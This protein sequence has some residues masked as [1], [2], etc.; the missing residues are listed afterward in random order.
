[1]VEE[2]L[3][4]HDAVDDTID[5]A[6]E[7][8][9]VVTDDEEINEPDYA[10]ENNSLKK[11][12]ED[13][14]R[15]ED[16]FKRQAEENARQ[17]EASDN[18]LRQ[19]QE[20]YARSQKEARDAQVDA[21]ESALAAATAEADKAEQDFVTAGEIGDHAS[22]AKAQRRIAAAVTKIERLESD[23]F[24]MEE[25]AKAE[26]Q[27]R[28]QEQPQPQ[29]DPMDRAL[30]QSGLPQSAQDWL[31]KHPEYFNDARKNAKIQNLHYEVIED[32]KAPFSQE[33]FE[34]IEEHLGMRKKA[35]DP[36][37]EIDNRP[38]PT[39][40]QATSVQAPPSREVPNSNGQ[41][42]TGK[43]SLT[44]AEYEHAKAAGVTPDEYIKQKMRL[45][46]MREDGTYGG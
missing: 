18:R 13:L 19:Q 42:P 43:I 1:V 23:K 31:K 9:V 35:E 22:Q 38:A 20:D 2:H 36:E 29:G 10:A 26:P 46:Q 28:Q 17:R 11:Q 44:K 27:Q 16:A 12:L 21:I 3:E 6:E 32:G 7:P 40:K 24:R 45:K 34:A 41:R 37:V 39:K 25:R 8:E 33:Y 4:R 30:K 5:D 15:S 14:R